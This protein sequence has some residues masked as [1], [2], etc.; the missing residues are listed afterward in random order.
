LSIAASL[1]ASG[2]QQRSCEFARSPGSTTSCARRKQICVASD[3]GVTVQFHLQHHCH[4]HCHHLC[5]HHLR[6]RTQLLHWPPQSWLLRQHL[7]YH[8]QCSC[9]GLR[10]PRL[11]GAVCWSRLDL[12]FGLKTQWLC[13]LHSTLRLASVLQMRTSWEQPDDCSGRWRLDLGRWQRS[14]ASL[15][16]AMLQLYKQQCRQQCPLVF[17]AYI[18]NLHNRGSGTWRLPV[19][20]VRHRKS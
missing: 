10:M 15:R 13:G 18:W 3:H 20:G 6:Y 2:C 12:Q 5:H 19:L 16:G 4:H 8:L 17:P 7:Q 11:R 14:A 1:R 9:Q